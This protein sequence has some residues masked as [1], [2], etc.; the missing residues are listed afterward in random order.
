MLVSAVRPRIR[1]KLLRV[2]TIALLVG[3]L[4]CQ[5]LADVERIAGEMAEAKAYVSLLSELFSTG[6]YWYEGYRLF[7]Q[8]LLAGSLAGFVFQRVAVSMLRRKGHLRD[9]D[10]FFFPEEPRRFEPDDFFS[11]G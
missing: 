9:L 3:L 5:N 2:A 11:E 6:E 1:A 7:L 4:G 10:H 8:V